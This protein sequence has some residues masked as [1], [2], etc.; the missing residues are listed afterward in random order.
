MIRW[1]AKFYFWI[2]GWKITG[3]WPREI[4]K[5]VLVAAGHTA[6]I[7]FLHTWFTFAILRVPW[8]FTIKEEWMRWPFGGFMRRLGAIPINRK[9]ST[10]M[11]DQMIQ[12]LKEREKLVLL[13]T[14]E[15]TRKKTGHW[16]KGFYHIAM[17]AQ[18]PIVLGFLDYK[19]KIGGVGITVHPTG[20]MKADL[21]KI[22]DFFASIQPKYPERFSLDVEYM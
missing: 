13:V 9:A 14:P 15:G 6:N 19:N 22:M 8:R 20:D 4:D 10:G 5:C 12:M 2:T 21:K 17:G 16:K 11:V 1:I 18:V 3:T 7:D